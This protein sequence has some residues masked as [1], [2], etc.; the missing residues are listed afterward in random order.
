MSSNIIPTDFNYLLK[1][2]INSKYANSIVLDTEITFDLFNYLKDNNLLY[3]FNSVYLS[4]YVPLEILNNKHFDINWD[5]VAERKDLTDQFIM[6]NISKINIWKLDNNI[7]ISFEIMY[8]IL[9]D[10]TKFYDIEIVI[11]KL[12]KLKNYSFEKFYILFELLMSNNNINYYSYRLNQLGNNSVNYTI[13]NFYK[14]FMENYYIDNKPSN[15]FN[16]IKFL[17]IFSKITNVNIL[18]YNYLSNN[19]LNKLTDCEYNYLIENDLIN[20]PKYYDINLKKPIVNKILKILYANRHNLINKIINPFI[21]K[22]YNVYQ[23]EELIKCSFESGCSLKNIWNYISDNILDLS[24]PDWFW[25]KNKLHIYWLY[26]TEN[27]IKKLNEEDSLMMNLFVKWMYDNYDSIQQYFLPNIPEC[28]IL[29]E[30]MIYCFYDSP[31]FNLEN[32]LGFQKI[33]LKIL[34]CIIKKDDDKYIKNRVLNYKHWDKISYF[35]I[36]DPTFIKKYEDRLNWNFLK[37]NPTWNLYPEEEFHKLPIKDETN[38][39]LWCSIDEKIN[40]LNK[41][42]IN[43]KATKQGEYINLN[44]YEYNILNHKFR[45][46][47][48]HYNNSNPRL[49]CIKNKYLNMNIN[50]NWKI[51]KNKFKHSIIPFDKFDKVVFTF[52]PSIMDGGISKWSNAFNKTPNNYVPLIK[53]FVSNNPNYNP[54]KD[55]VNIHYKNIIIAGKKNNDANGILLYLPLYESMNFTAQ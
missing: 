3:Y 22:G 31:L 11:H 40:E 21:I 7:Q 48:Q 1:I 6:K 8:N 53:C 43:F 9:K 35:Q 29:P 32:V 34:N 55:N 50:D 5:I 19:L 23:L 36:L 52:D 24:Y 44:I 16:L 30:I 39:Y 27:I 10:T 45:N 54:C 51:R 33:S 42:N 26:A 14:L 25:K 12:L 20:Y 49:T 46:Y 41:Y 17:K 18:N 15:L 47:D 37:Y 2:L 4:R 28:L 13:N 38:K